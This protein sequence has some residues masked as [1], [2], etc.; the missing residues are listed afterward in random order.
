MACPS[1]G[2]TSPSRGFHATQIGRAYD[3][4]KGSGNWTTSPGANAAA[5]SFGSAAPNAPVFTARAA[6]VKDEQDNSIRSGQPA[7]A[8]AVVSCS[9]Y[10][11]PMEVAKG[12]PA[13]RLQYSADWIRTQ[14]RAG[15]LPAIRFNRRAWRFHWPTAIFMKYR[16]TSLYSYATL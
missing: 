2:R 8:A 6:W 5:A 10:W 14:V 3:F 11:P 7:L 15:R 9:R 4:K 16:A 12:N 13:K 1:T